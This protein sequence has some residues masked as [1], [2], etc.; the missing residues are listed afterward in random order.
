[1]DYQREVKGRIH[2]VGD[3][4]A[5]A[6]RLVPPATMHLAEDHDVV[7]A[8]D[9]SGSMGAGLGS[10]LREATRAAEN[11]IRRLPDNMH[12]GVVGFDHEAHLLCPLAAGKRKALRAV[13]SI[14][15]GGGTAIHAALH[16]S[17]EA[18]SDGRSGVSKTIV[19]LSDGGSE[20]ATALGT[21]RLIHESP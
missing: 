12:V 9:H 14:S 20:H 18:F 1:A 13:G 19:L 16:R 2:S 11:F 21:A 5:V 3:S 8:I 4:V 6:L 15:A 17:Q 7:M 10:P